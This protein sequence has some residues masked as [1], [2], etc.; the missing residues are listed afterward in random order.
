MPDSPTPEAELDFVCDCEWQFR[1]ACAGESFYGEEQGKRYCVLHFPSQDKAVDFDAAVRRKFGD[2]DFNF[3]GVWFPDGFSFHRFTFTGE[4]H[5][6]CAT[7]SGKADF[8]SATFKGDVSFSSA[9][10]N[11]YADFMATTFDGKADFSSVR[12]DADASFDGTFNGGTCFCG[13]I[14]E[15]RAR[16]GG[17]FNGETDFISAVF[18][19]PVS[20]STATFND[21]V[22]FSSVTFKVKVHFSSAY[23]NHDAFFRYAI[24]SGASIFHDAT[25]KAAAL[26]GYATFDAQTDFTDAI[27]PGLLEFREASF[28]DELRFAGNQDQGHF[29]AKSSL[30]LQ[31]A[32]I[33]RPELVSFHSLNLHPHWFINTDAR[34]F[35]FINVQ[36]TNSG[37]AKPELEL[38]KSRN[39]ESPHRLLAIACQRLAVNCEDNS[40][41]RSASHF[42]RMALDAESLETWC[43]FDVRKLNWWYWLASGYGERPFQALIV[44][45]GILLLFGALYT[46]VGFARW[47][48]RV[49]TESDAATSRRDEVGAPLPFSRALTYSAGVMT[50]QRPEPKPATTAAQT[51]VLLETILGPVQAALLALAIRRKFMR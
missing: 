3:R 1:S 47:E 20:F 17:T 6:Y 39:V 48:P 14:F 34:K 9:T 12:F 26:F 50:L 2:Q 43:G 33:E 10:V 4:A 23:F 31:F 7:F 45:V 46:K 27:F 51:V 15:T 37:N 44:L 18:E 22:Y 32:R 8:Q 16:F 36:W 25:F 29:G 21:V 49:A 24:F 30:E 35:E 42:R 13:A 41:Y 5:F 11:G 38:L 19:G 28:K 40:R